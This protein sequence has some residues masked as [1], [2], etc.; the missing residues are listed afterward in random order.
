MKYLLLILSVS[1]FTATATTNTRLTEKLYAEESYPYNLLVER[2][3]SIKINYIEDLDKKEVSCS[4]TVLIDADTATT[5]TL[6]SS[7]NAF[8]IRPLVSCLGHADAK[9]LLGR[10]FAQ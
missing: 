5:T 3:D 7:Y 9:R 6:V 4:T 2:A 1:A 10:T 8:K